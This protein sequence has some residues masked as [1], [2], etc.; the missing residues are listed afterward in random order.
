MWR[1]KDKSLSGLEVDKLRKNY[2]TYF[3]LLL[4][5]GAMT[6]F[7]VC[8]P[9]SQR[10]GAGAVRGSAAT[11]DGEVITRS[12]FNRAYRAA[13]ER[14]QR[15]FSESFDPSALQLAQS[16]MKELVDDRA[17]YLK[18]VELGLRASDDEIV[19]LLAQAEQFK[20]EQTGQF[21]TEGFQRFLDNQGYTE[22]TFLE[23]IRRSV[24]VQ[25]FQRFVRDSVYVSERAA[26]LDYKLSETKLNVEFLKFDPQAMQV[27]VSNTEVDKLLADEAGKKKAK[28]YYDA[29]TKEF[30]QTE[31]VK[32]RHILISYKG[33]RNATAEAAKRDKDAAR[34]LAVSIEARVKAPDADFLAIAKETTDEAAGKTS[35][36]DLGWFGREAMVKEFSDAAFTQQPG[37]ISGL[38]ESPFGFH[39]IKVE[40]KKEAKSVA[41]EAAQAQIA[42]KILQ[43]E[44]RP[45]VA[46]EQAD[47]ILSEL[48]EG[49]DV[50]SQLAELKLT[51]ADTGDVAVNA[52]YVPGIG[53]SKEII[54]ALGA[55]NKVGQLSPTPVDV[56][57]NL[58]ILRL[59]SRQEADLSKLDKDKRRELAQTAAFSEGFAIYR[60]LEKNVTES[61]EA[62]KKV[63]MN[64]EYLALDTPREKPK[65]NSKPSS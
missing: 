8:D 59:K 58:Y 3:V 40:D 25:K 30:N 50:A 21:D 5:L 7:G 41:F 22:A 34:Q 13:Y 45:A 31:Q 4:A 48:K 24:T 52:S 56:R 11:V 49:K 57:G 65:D 63:W 6:F 62:N 61:L 27:N 1:M 44:K 47:K 16:V 64:P 17:M 51:W 19:K 14:Y 46:K 36:G 39:I 28:E 32:A 43:K 35:G 18:A 42:E 29:N 12:E 37:T 55:L 15:Q 33:A 60:A 20:N 53:S 10:G 9:T 54:N 2:T 38:V 23:E 26:E